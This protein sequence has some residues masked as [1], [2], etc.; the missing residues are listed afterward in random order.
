MKSMDCKAFD[1]KI[2]IRQTNTPSRILSINGK[3]HL[4]KKMTIV[5]TLNNVDIYLVSDLP[6]I[7]SFEFLLNEKNPLYHFIKTINNKNQRIIASTNWDLRHRTPQIDDDILLWITNN[8][9]TGVVKVE[10]VSSFIKNGD[11]ISH[12]LAT[13]NED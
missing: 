3:L 2:F 10:E 12:K 1:A 4:E 8:F 5:Y 6:A 9:K 11:R 13:T 7:D